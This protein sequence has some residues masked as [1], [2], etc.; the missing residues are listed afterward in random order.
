MT[1]ATSLTNAVRLARL[2][3]PFFP[4]S[5]VQHMAISGDF[6]YVVGLR[7]TNGFGY[8][9]GLLVLNVA[10]PANPGA[11]GSFHFTPSP[12]VTGFTIS[13]NVCYVA[14]E[15]RG[16]FNEATGAT[17]ELIGLSDPEPQTQGSFADF[18][19]GFPTVDKTDL[20][21]V[22]EYAY[23]LDWLAGL[24]VFDLTNPSRPVPCGRV[25]LDGHPRSVALSGDFAYVSVGLADGTFISPSGLRVVDVSNPSRPAL[26]G[27]F[28]SEVPSQGIA[29]TRG[30]A[31]LLEPDALRV[32]DLT[33][34]SKSHLVTTVPILG[35]RGIA[36][37]RTY[38]Y[39][40]A[41]SDLLVFNVADPGS[42]RIVGRLSNAGGNSITVAG[43]RIS[44][45]RDRALIAPRSGAA[46]AGG[47]L[48][49]LG[50]SDPVQPKP[51]GR[52][53]ATASN[54]G[55]VTSDS[56]TYLEDPEELWLLRDD[57]DS[58]NPVLI[59]G[60]RSITRAFGIATTGYY[61]FTTRERGVR[62]YDVAD[63]LNPK[64]VGTS[65]VFGF[66]ARLAYANGRVYAVGDFGHL[67][68]LRLAPILESI[69]RDDGLVHL[70]WSAFAPARVL[71]ASRLDNADWT[72]IPGSETTNRLDLPIEGETGFFRIL[73]R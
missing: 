27:R 61:A 44:L 8:Q 50:I 63:R 6:L 10:D 45:W 23:A 62:V 70:E 47:E 17:L 33:T 3:Q 36:V 73:R 68:V 38:A 12:G 35:A 5:S 66:P 41:R 56:I 7:P 37:D 22:G 60:Y 1:D 31:L 30:H 65:S 57:R 4:D 18:S 13:G 19:A 52:Y 42:P 16:I 2:Y 14:R 54:L 64:H 43:G 29:V 69:R 72:E 71:R 11:V 49:I 15:S 53:S 48:E 20:A 34:P 25:D 24:Q 28:D 39:V 9:T 67:S 51:I 40:G 59:G 21:A 58:R 55:F 26:I 32:L 46:S